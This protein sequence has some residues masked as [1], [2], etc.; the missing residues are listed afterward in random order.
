[1]PA[2]ARG[3]DEDDGAEGTW[4]MNR[5]ADQ[6]G[7]FGIARMDRNTLDLQIRLWDKV[8]QSLPHVTTSVR[9]VGELLLH[10]GLEWPD[11]Q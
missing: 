9:E 2:T 6:L 4:R 1:M 3:D 5:A 8:E 7:T 10:M 11:K